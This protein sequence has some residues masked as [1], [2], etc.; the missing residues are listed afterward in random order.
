MKNN[1]S[2]YALVKQVTTPYAECVEAIK[3]A[4][5]QQG[6]GILTEIDVTATLKN[7]ID[8]DY[9]KTVILGAC[10]PK[11]A[12]QALSAKPDVAVLLPCNMVVRE[13]QQGQVEISALNPLFMGEIIDQSD[14]QA[15][16]EQAYQKIKLAMDQV[17]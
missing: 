8:V 15:V 16:V 13:N 9:P 17:S 1:V 10:N 6:F 3:A 14:V 4:L 12:H 5:A 11:L 2:N 7:K